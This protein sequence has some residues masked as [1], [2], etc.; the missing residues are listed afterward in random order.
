SLRRLHC[1]TQLQPDRFGMEQVR[2]HRF[3]LRRHKQRKLGLR[4]HVALKID[5]WCDLQDGQPRRLQ[6]HHAT[7]GD[8]HDLLPL[9]NSTGA[10][11]GD[12]LDGFDKFLY[13]TFAPDVTPAVLDFERGTGRE[14]AREGDPLRPRSDIDKTAGSG[15][16][17]RSYSKLG[18]IY[19]AVA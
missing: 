7:L 13:L 6:P 9:L 16:H 10:R 11:E 4:Q 12:L 18:D 3:Q 14:E 19:A 5:A 17:M 8:I 1:R 2:V 15:R